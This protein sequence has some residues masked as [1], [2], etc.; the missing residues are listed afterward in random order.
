MGEGLLNAR[1][2]QENLWPKSSLVRPVARHF[3]C[4][5]VSTSSAIHKLLKIQGYLF[6]RFVGIALPLER[7]TAAGIKCNRGAE[8]VVENGMKVRSLCVAWRSLPRATSVIIPE[9]RPRQSQILTL[10]P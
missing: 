10:R 4:F 3:V 6:T 2:A 5:I 7:F 8:V 9:R 1:G